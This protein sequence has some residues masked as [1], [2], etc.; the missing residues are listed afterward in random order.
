MENTKCF[1]PVTL[2]LVVLAVSC[3]TTHRLQ[4]IKK[5]EIAASL[6]LPDGEVKMPT[7]SLPDS[8]RD[9]LRIVDFEGNQ[10]LIMN[11]I[12]DVDGEMVATDRITA[13]YVTARFRNV[14]ERHGKVDIEFQVRVPR[15]MLDSK[16]QLQLDPDMFMLGDSLRLDPVLITGSGYRKAQL[17]GYQQYRRFLES[18]VTDTTIF[19]NKHDLEI[20]LERNLPRIYAL[21]NDSTYVSDDV[22]ASMYG[23]TEREAIDHYTYGF[24]VRRNKR[25]IGMKDAMYR[26]Y[27]KAPIVSEGIK[28]DTVIR[29]SNGDFIYNYIQTINTVPA[30]RKVDIC[31]SGEIREQDK[32]LYTIP[33][34]EPLTFYI[35]SLASLA[36]NK[37][38]YIDKVISRKVRANTA[39]YIEF[40]QGKWNVEPELGNNPDEIGRIKNNIRGLVV[41]EEYDLDSIT[42]ASFAS[43][44]GMIKSNEALSEKRAAAASDFF[45]RYASGLRDSLLRDAGAYLSFEGAAAEKPSIPHIHF[46]SRSGGENWPMLDAL[47]ADDKTLDE[48]FKEYYL[49][50]SSLNKNLDEREKALASHQSYRYLREHLYPRLRIVKFDFYL[51]RRGMVHD[52]IHTTELDTVYMRGVQL[53]RDREYNEALKVLRPYADYNTAVAAVATDRNASAAEILSSLPSDARTDYL[54]AIISSR[55]GDDRSAVDYYLRACARDGAYVHRGRLDP[56][57]SNLIKKYDLKM[58]SRQE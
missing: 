21:K 25:R 35:S 44:E 24:L 6:T 52:T 26:R 41:N 15:E 55:Q 13:S 23:V 30:L 18:I 42:I 56:E 14:A 28:L 8:P 39:C 11:A 22:F 9:T 47:V 1:L 48:E 5:S 33:R 51:H 3:A 32:R 7:V 46:R 40:R 38:R 43:P 57:I 34:S 27:V 58:D 31:L 4:Q 49:R 45:G 12:K 17:R 16:W 19:I 2:F 37:E 53:I 20:F 50:V 36:D 10:T 29:D 54:R